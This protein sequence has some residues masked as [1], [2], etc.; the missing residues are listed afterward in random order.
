MESR[1]VKSQIFGLESSPRNALKVMTSSAQGKGFSLC[2][3]T[4]VISARDRERAAN[5]FG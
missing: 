1:N 3:E 5:F 2:A 4:V